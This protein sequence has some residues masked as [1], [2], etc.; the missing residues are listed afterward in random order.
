MWS[1]ARHNLAVLYRRQGRLAN[2]ESQLQAC[3]A[4]QP[5][6]K[7]AWLGLGHI[8]LDQG[9]MDAA[10][11]AARQLDAV[12]ELSAHAQALRNRAAG[13]RGRGRRLLS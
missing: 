10:E 13:R 2:A 6:Y 8:W 3:L 11:D 12:P 1:K 9:K 5:D 4:E 7:I